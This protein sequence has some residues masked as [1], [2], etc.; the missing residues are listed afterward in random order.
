MTIYFGFQCCKFPPTFRSSPKAPT[1]S[2]LLQKLSPIL[3]S[4]SKAKH[5]LSGQLK[6]L[7][8]YFPVHSKS[9]SPTFRSTHKASPP[10]KQTSTSNIVKINIREGCRLPPK[11]T[12][13]VFLGKGFVSKIKHEIHSIT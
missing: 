3:R 7:V 11:K 6:K 4:T 10:R 9:L 8:P 5:P 13:N 1:L 12:A 2:G